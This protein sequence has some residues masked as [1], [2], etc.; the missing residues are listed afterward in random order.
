MKKQLYDYLRYAYSLT[1]LECVELKHELYI[2]GDQHLLN[3]S[4][5]K[6]LTNKNCSIGSV[7]Y[8]H[9][10]RK[11]ARYWEKIWQRRPSKD[12]IIKMNLD[13]LNI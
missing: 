10:T 6:S 11:G 12:V 5:L 9:R 3:K 8:F 2:R 13:K 7:M 4:A 1:K